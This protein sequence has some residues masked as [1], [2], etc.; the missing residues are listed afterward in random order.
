MSTVYIPDIRALVEPLLGTPYAA[1]D[2][3]DLARHL[4]EQGFG[5]ALARDTQESAQQ[6][7]E[8]WYR[9]DATDFLTLVQPWDLIVTAT[10]EALPVGDGVGVAVDAS[11]FVYASRHDTGVV[12][13]RLRSWRPRILQIARLRELL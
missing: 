9:G 7:Q 11:K 5:T 3:W 6:F 2:C 10:H 1:Y 4:Y 13:G 8:L 12:L